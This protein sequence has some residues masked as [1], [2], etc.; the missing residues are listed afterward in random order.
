MQL[1]EFGNDTITPRG[2]TSTGDLAEMGGQGMVCAVDGAMAWWGVCRVALIN[3]TISVV[4]S[5]KGRPGESPASLVFPPPLS[6]C[7]RT[8]PLLART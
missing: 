5:H 6:P 1:V 7:R 8:A 4:C 3:T 2:V